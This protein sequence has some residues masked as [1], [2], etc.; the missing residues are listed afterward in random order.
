ML[1]TDFNRH[2]PFSS[3]QRIWSCLSW[4][5]P[6]RNLIGSVFE[7]Q[8]SY[9]SRRGQKP[10]TAAVQCIYA[11]I[12]VHSI[13]MYF[14]KSSLSIFCTGFGVNRHIRWALCFILTIWTVYVMIDTLVVTL[15]CTPTHKAWDLELKGTV[16]AFLSSESLLI[17]LT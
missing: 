14:V 2:S 10:Y 6:T 4:M 17:V 13:G 11:E 3:C 12:L 5:G 7:G 1:C 16:S 9:R 15:Q 8:S